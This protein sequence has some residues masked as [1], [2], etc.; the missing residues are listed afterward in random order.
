MR[1]MQI[2]PIL[3]ASGMGL[4]PHDVEGAGRITAPMGQQP[5]MIPKSGYRFS[6]RIMLQG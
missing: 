4:T 3:R 1:P 6:E 2:Q 5:S